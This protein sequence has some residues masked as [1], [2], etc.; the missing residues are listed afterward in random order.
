MGRLVQ[1]TWSVTP[2]MEV[3]YIRFLIFRGFFLFVISIGE[4][5]NWAQFILKLDACLDGM[6]VRSEVLYSFDLGQVVLD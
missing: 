6:L 3:C 4:V 1:I 2:E 5:G